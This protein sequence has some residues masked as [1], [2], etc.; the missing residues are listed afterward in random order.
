MNLLKRIFNKPNYE[1][2][3]RGVYVVR[4]QAGFRNAV[5]EF[6]NPEDTKRMFQEME[7]YPKSYPSLICLAFEYRGYHYVRVTAVPLNEVKE[8]LSRH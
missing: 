8:V 3:A 2:I 6:A 5:K 1:R 7:G 4:T